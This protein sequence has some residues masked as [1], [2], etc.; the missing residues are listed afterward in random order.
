M[1]EADDYAANIRQLVALVKGD[2]GKVAKYLRSEM[3][4]AAGVLNFEYAA[5]LRDRLK[6]VEEFAA[7]QTIIFPDEVDRDVF[8]LAIEDDDGCLVIIKAR[9]GRVQGRE[10]FFVKGSRKKSDNEIISTLLQQYYF[11]AT[12]IPRE[13]Y[14]PAEPEDLE[15]IAQW[16]RE[17]RSGAVD[18]IIPQRGR[19]A[20]LLR[21]ADAN[22]Q[23]LLGEKRRETEARDRIPH[24]LK[25]LQEIL[26]LESPPRRIEA[27][28]ISNLQGKHTV[29]SMVVFKD[30]RPLKT[31]YRRFNIKTVSGIDDFAS[32][33]E[34]VG[35]RY[36]RVLNEDREL[37]DLILIDGGKGQLSAALRSLRELEVNDQPIIGLAKKLEEVFTPY[38]SE[39]INIPKTSSALK[40]LQQVRDEAHRVA[41]THHRSQ[42]SKSAFGSTLDNIPGVGDNRKRKLLSH[43]KTIKNISQ[44]D[45]LQIASVPGIDSRTAESVFYYFNNNND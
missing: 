40:L 18:I 28:D 9:S 29:A 7:R 31:E 37:P 12:F 20:K 44:A 10:H 43:F 17:K 14:L 23:M 22:A 8:G 1:V 33:N 15:T 41:I 2:V 5:K 35:R 6:V 24:S 3:K 13:I 4:I 25:A 27:F 39:A 26:R 19:R 11:S 32:M 16:L 42:R 45:I 34:V 38:E 36:R 30:G 21:L